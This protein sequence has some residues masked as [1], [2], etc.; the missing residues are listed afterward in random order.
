MKSTAF[1]VTE[2]KQIVVPADNINRTIYLHTLGNGTIYIGGSD[3]TTTN[4]FLTE[5][6]AVPFQFF[7]PAGEELWA[8]TATATTEQLR[9]LTPSVD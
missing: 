5:K 2:T 8:V 6:N 7:L 3:V 4:G 1:T 9:V